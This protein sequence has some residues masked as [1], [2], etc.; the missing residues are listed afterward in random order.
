[1][2]FLG[3]SRVSTMGVE[4]N[5]RD[6]MPIVA[7]LRC[8]RCIMDS[9]D[10][11]L[12]LDEEG[13]CQHCRHYFE[14][15]RIE[16]QHGAQ[17][18]QRML[19]KIKH[20]GRGRAYDCVV[21]VSGGIDSTY[22]A[23]K[24]KMLG[25]RPLAVH[26]DNGWNSELAVSNIEAT[27]KTLGI[28]LFTY[29]VDWPEFKDLQ[30]S[31]FKASVPNIE[32]VTDH[33]ITACLMQTAADHGIKTVILGANLE[34][35]GIMPRSWLYDNKDF[36][37]I[38]KIHQRFGKVRIATYPILS[39]WKLFRYF[40][41]KQI[42]FVRLLNFE[43]YNKAEAAKLLEKEI[44]WRPYEGKHFESIF[45][46]FFQG[47]ILP[48]KFGMDK[49]IAHFST[50]ICSGQMTRETALKEMENPPYDQKLVAE[51]RAY[52]IKKFDISEKYFD[53]MMALPCKSHFDYP[54]LRWILER[55]LFG[56]K[57]LARRLALGDE[58]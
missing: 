30:L 50:L 8:K 19:E 56:L 40:F 36:L 48:V 41:L 51:D 45:T 17:A 34:S 55:D 21:G 53:E 29:V 54:S 10:P 18:L 23:W 26:F 35:E 27:L 11:E 31:F 28:D 13:V 38:R 6:V 25:L 9:S 42:K 22:V 49:R 47:Y 24:A 33:A 46:R 2:L 52:V 4:A 16:L 37:Q 32:A 1:M 58:E 15:S 39:W 44:G 14:R 5:V 43:H 7:D 20:A 3:D 12:S 57:R